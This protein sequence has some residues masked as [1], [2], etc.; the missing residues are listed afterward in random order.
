MGKS[1]EKYNQL[2]KAASVTIENQSDLNR[3]SVLHEITTAITSTLDLR[4]VLVASVRFQNFGENTGLS[5]MTAR[6]I[7]ACPVSFLG[8]MSSLVLQATGQPC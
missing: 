6:H 3:L 8:R 1:A 4:T 7:T 5:M 2:A